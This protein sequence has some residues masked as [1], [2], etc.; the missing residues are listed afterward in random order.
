MLLPLERG[1]K[2]STPG[3]VPPSP[4]AIHRWGEAGCSRSKRQ[5]GGI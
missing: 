4:R 3:F 1:A 5:K 2:A